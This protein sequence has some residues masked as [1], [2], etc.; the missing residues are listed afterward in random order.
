MRLFTIQSKIW[1]AKAF[2]KAGKTCAAAERS[3][4]GSF[5]PESAQDT[6][7]VVAMSTPM[8]VS[9]GQVSSADVAY[10]LAGFLFQN[11]VVLVWNVRLLALRCNTGGAFVA[12]RAFVVHAEAAVV[13]HMLLV[14]HADVA[15]I[16]IVAL[17]DP[18]R[19]IDSI[20]MMLMLDLLQCCG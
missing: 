14:L 6:L 11:Q 4:L 7:V 2:L 18:I 16:R 9:L 10:T 15:P 17:E 8:P 3:Q 5:A 20:E 1:Q 13:G 12:I 19:A